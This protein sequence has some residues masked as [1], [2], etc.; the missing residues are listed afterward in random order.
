MPPPRNLAPRR[1]REGRAVGP[2]DLELE[3]V[4]EAMAA[5]WGREGLRRCPVRALRDVAIPE[6]SK[7][8]LSEYGLPAY[9]GQAF[10]A[11][12]GDE[13]PRLSAGR[14]HYRVL[15]VEPN[16]WGGQNHICLDERRAG[17]VVALWDGLTAKEDEWH[18]NTSVEALAAH[19]VLHRRLLT[20]TAALEEA[21][22][23]YCTDPAE[24]GAFDR[25]FRELLDRTE[26]EMRRCDPRLWEGMSGTAFDYVENA[27]GTWEGYWAVL[28]GEFGEYGRSGQEALP[29]WTGQ[30]QDG[31][32]G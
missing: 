25:A 23:S 19:M 16:Q 15:G 5:L 8:L 2:E 30:P 20:E 22:P 18:V 11:D 6:A 12:V 17:A 29:F 3:S 28:L 32:Q 4:G 14:P 21:L 10:L 24:G 27:E 31:Q 9:W 7:R 1:R 26:R 13:L